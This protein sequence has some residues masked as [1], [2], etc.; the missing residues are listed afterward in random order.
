[1]DCFSNHFHKYFILTFW[2]WKHFLNKRQ[3]EITV[4][5]MVIVSFLQNILG[6]DSTYSS[7]LFKKSFISG[8]IQS[9][10]S[11]KVCFLWW[12]T[13]LLIQFIFLI[14]FGIAEIYSLKGF[15]KKYFY[16][17][18]WS[19]TLIFFLLWHRF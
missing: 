11:D 6:L 10:G 8:I 3:L 17:S 2:N 1:M 16:M 19:E 18:I 15:L 4:Y 12:S 5:L 14:V 7:F 9:F 13:I